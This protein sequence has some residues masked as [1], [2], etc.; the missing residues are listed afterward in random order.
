MFIQQSSRVEY[1]SIKATVFDDFDF[2]NGLRDLSL[3]QYD[4]EETWI[5]KI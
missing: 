1:F 2:I 3:S 5:D 4:N